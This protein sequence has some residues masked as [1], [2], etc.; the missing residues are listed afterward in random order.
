MNE[1]NEDHVIAAKDNRVAIGFA[2]IAFLLACMA[3][4]VLAPYRSLYSNLIFTLQGVILVW[5]VGSL[6]NL[7]IPFRFK[8]DG[9]I[10]KFIFI[11]TV[12]ATGGRLLKA[13]AGLFGYGWLGLFAGASFF[14]FY[15]RKRKAV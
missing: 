3:P 12:I 6:P 14:S 11:V 15:L 13:D 10:L 7:K 9:W 4:I 1:R 8:D 5:F 2:W